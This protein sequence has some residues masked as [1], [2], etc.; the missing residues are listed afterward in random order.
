MDYLIYGIGWGLWLAIM[1]GPLV[2]A[3]IQTTIEKGT[4][5]GLTVGLGIWFSDALF[6]LAF[7]FA[8]ENMEALTSYPNFEVIVG[9]IGGIILFLVGTGIY[10]NTPTE[11]PKP[12]FKASKNVLANSAKGF[13]INTFN[14]FTFV[15]WL[16]MIPSYVKANTLSDSEIFIFILGIFGTIIFTDSLKVFFAKKLQPKLTLKNII[17]VRKI[18]GAALVI[19]GIVLIIRVLT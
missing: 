7:F 5:A 13:A 4:P 15:F 1:V 9:I 18:S 3:L 2:F 8:A 16:A 14:P 6:V 10:L 19:F 11:L 12:S 17:S